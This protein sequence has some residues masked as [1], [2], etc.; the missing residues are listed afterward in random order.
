MTNYKT[1]VSS[2]DRSI[3]YSNKAFLYFTNREYKDPDNLMY[4]HFTAMSL[5]NLHDCIKDY[6]SIEKKRVVLKKIDIK[7]HILEAIYDAAMVEGVERISTANIV[8]DIIAF[9][10][11]LRDKI[12]VIETA[13]EM[14]A[15]MKEKVK[16][17]ES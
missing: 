2:I 8:G 10:E 7:R 12:R 5:I 1:I 16:G 17:V 9:L 13:D 4:V 14:D 3:E 15:E 11:E 6:I